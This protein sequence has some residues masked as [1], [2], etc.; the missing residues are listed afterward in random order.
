MHFDVFHRLADRLV[1]ANIAQTVNVL[2]AM[3]LTD[4]ETGALVRTPTYHVFEMNKVH[5]DATIRPVHVRAPGLVRDVDRPVPCPTLS[6]LGERRRRPMPR[7]GVEHRPGERDVVVDLD[8]RGGR[9]GRRH[10]AAARAR[11]VRSACNTAQNPAA[12]APR[13]VDGP[14]AHRDRG[15]ARPCHRTRSRLSRPPCAAEPER[16]SRARAS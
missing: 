4:E 3:L 16:A 15:P 1:M 14:G 12:V 5:H 9:G 7:L 6:A 11:S 13:A 10:G 8:L 2:Q